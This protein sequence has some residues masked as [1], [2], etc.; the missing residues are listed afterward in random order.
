ML[1]SSPLTRFAVIF[2]LLSLPPPA[3]AQTFQN[4]LLIPTSSDASSVSTADVN[5]DGK[6]D[7]I[8][9]DGN[10]YGQMALHILL[11]KGNGNFVHGQDIAVPAGICCAITIADVTGDGRLDIILQGALP[12]QLTSE[13]AVLP[14]NGDGTFQAPIVTTFQ[15]P[16]IDGNPGFASPVNVGDINGDGKADLVVTDTTNGVISL[17]LGDNSGS[18]TFAGSIL[19][20]TRSTA[21]LTDLNSDGK[22][23]IIATDNSGALFEVFLGNGDGT[24]QNFVRYSLGM[25][26]GGFILTDVDGDG[27]LDMLASLYPNQVVYFKGNANGTFAPFV[28][29]GSFPSGN[30]FVGIGDFNG[31]HIVDL[32]FVN[33]TG[34]GV[35]L[36]LGV[37][38]G[39]PAFGVLHT[40]VSGGS[41]SPYSTYLFYPGLV[42]GDFNGDGKQDLAMPVEGGISILLGKGDGTFDSVPYY[43]MGQEVGAAAVA[44]FSGDG[45]ED[46]AV[47]LPATFPRLL[48]GDGTGNFTLGPDP[49]PSY[50][51]TGAD[52]TLLT[53]DFNGDGKPDLNISDLIPNESSAAAQSVAL[54]LGH[55]VFAAPVVVPNGSTIMAD[56]NGDGRTDILDITGEQVIVSLGQADGS[57]NTVTTNIRI[58]SDSGHANVG[59]VNNDGKPDLIIN[60]GDHMEVWLGNGDGTFAYSTSTSL[61][62]IGPD[63]LAAIADVDGDGNADALYTPNANAAVAVSPLE[64][65]YG[66]GDGTFQAPVSIP[67]SHRYW[68]V[69]VADVNK[70]GKPDMVFTD[71]ASIAVMLNLGNRTFDSE[72][73]YIA[74]RS[75]SALNV[76][77]V[78]SD[79]YPDIVVAN[80]G[81]TT[82]TVLFN[83]PQ[84]NSGAG[85]PVTGTLSIAPEPSI[86]GQPFTVTLIVASQASG[87]TVP[88]GLVS[89]SLDGVFLADAALSN[90][91]ASCTITTT[92]TP[93]PHAITASYGGD[94]NYG[95]KTFAIEHNV[96]PPTYATTTALSGIPAMILAAQT[97]RLTAT[98]STSISVP[99]G[100]VT[101]LDGANTL[102]AE[103]ID[104]T[105][106]ALLDTALLTPGSHSLSAKYEG[107]SQVGFT[108]TEQTYVAAIFSPSTSAAS[109]ISVTTDATTTS[110]TTS[111]APATA[112]TV[113]TFTA[114]T[115]SMAGM[116]FGGVAYFDGTTLLGTISLNSGTAAFSTA[117]L[118][119]GTHT[120]TA[121]FNANGPYAS[122]TS[123]PLSETITAASTDVASTV[124]SLVR[125]T[126]A[127]GNTSSLSATIS[128][129]NSPSAGA[130]TFLDDGV[131][132]GTVAL[133][134]TGVARLQLAQL[135]GGAH[136]FSASYSGTSQFAP[137]ASPILNEQW[138]A[139]GPAFALQIQPSAT[140]AVA[141]A[142]TSFQ[143]TVSPF[144]NFQQMVKLS[145]ASGL[146]QGYSCEFSPSGIAGAGNSSLNIISSAKNAASPWSPKLWP[147]ATLLG[148]CAML[149][150]IS[151][152]RR[153][154]RLVWALAACSLLLTSAG[155]GNAA[156]SSTKLRTFVVTVQAEAGRGTNA[157]V[158]GAEIQMHLRVAM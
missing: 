60:Y 2:A 31:D 122:S 58:P 155:C 138:P 17:L 34:V 111:S 56:F 43:D 92:I 82:V 75:I 70:D 26:G 154:P 123:A 51:P 22:L 30:Q 62:N 10:P 102:G 90:G 45:Y 119:Q 88:T 1:R 127:T 151:R 81:G 35:E 113:V 36:G 65:F 126:D 40:T 49:N 28:T 61:Q 136:T 73:R 59:D 103:P 37:S 139:S 72:V 149:L 4:P 42:T 143:I 80:T 33:N 132:L 158:H 114:T 6:V 7:L 19:T 47:T 147:A 14:G 44:Q 29:L 142:A 9:L 24:F 63:T 86:S 134:G 39:E 77:D 23:D 135:T 84:N 153:N 67:L 125:E 13:V 3:L 110:L 20:Y 53:G 94:A 129:T 76:V 68:Q 148:M 91:A 100:V 109:A 121:T 69:T 137:S 115:S 156:P 116:P 157:V 133:D 95:P 11:G 108:A 131:I 54:N 120:I 145:C 57:F 16:D 93:I 8:Y 52:T 41:T 140:L 25:S 83:Q 27:H 101:F 107:Y 32:T 104:T 128:S 97:V 146:P 48:L 144:G 98:V 12:Y 117:S 152:R 150:G 96:L 99:A 38:N 112:G 64:I 21:Y 66:N 79:G 74:G 5:G 118:P 87:G 55:G 89:F 18:F 141:G 50:M 105:G 124:A 15:P 85:G 46:I 106:V 130:V 78:N 71:G